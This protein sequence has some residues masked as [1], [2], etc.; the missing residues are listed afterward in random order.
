M[1]RLDYYLKFIPSLEWRYK[2]LSGTNCL[3][4]KNTQTNKRKRNEKGR[5]YLF[6][7][8][9][10]RERK[11][12]YF[13]ERYKRHIYVTSV[14]TSRQLID[15]T[16]S[17]TRKVTYVFVETGLSSSVQLS[18]ESF[19]NAY[20]P[21]PYMGDKKGHHHFHGNSC[22][23]IRNLRVINLVKKESVFPEMTGLS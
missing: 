18:F 17:H 3:S 23:Q 13:L 14:V 4:Q 21:Y 12:P 8:F 5:G 9:R 16:G 22:N 1:F 10:E 11:A 2:P 7:L 19:T 6:S 20:C 15:I